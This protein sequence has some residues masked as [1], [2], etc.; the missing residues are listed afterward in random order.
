MAAANEYPRKAQPA[1]GDD[2]LA[3]SDPGS[4]GWSVVRVNIAALLQD[5]RN[6][7]ASLSTRFTALEEGE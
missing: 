6:R 7:T 5:L 1:N 4:P 3:V 2:I